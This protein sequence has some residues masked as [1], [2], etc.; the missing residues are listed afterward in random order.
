MDADNNT[1][2]IVF[3]S[4]ERGE[5]EKVRRHSAEH[6]FACG[7][8]KSRDLSTDEIEELGREAAR[9]IGLTA[10]GCWY[11][12]LIDELIK[13]Y[14]GNIVARAVEQHPARVE[15]ALRK[16]GSRDQYASD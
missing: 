14:P 6:C 4:D 2:R 16:R 11:D 10:H 12:G 8:E 5:V 13:H 9:A 1:V 15:A 7:T 3:F